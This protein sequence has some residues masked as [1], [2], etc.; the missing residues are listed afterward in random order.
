[1]ELHL[2]TNWSR[3]EVE[4]LLH[5]IPSALAGSGPDPHGLADGF[6]AR[7]ASGWMGMAKKDYDKREGSGSSGRLR[8][9]LAAGTLNERGPSASY[10]PPND[11]QFYDASKPGEVSVGTNVPY[12]RFQHNTKPLWPEDD[13][14]QEWSDEMLRVAQLGISKIVEMV[15]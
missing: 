9:S 8:E 2:Q 10:V 11:D 12:A 1:M 4:G 5:S 6:K 3:E 7:L 14:P 15:G 13:L